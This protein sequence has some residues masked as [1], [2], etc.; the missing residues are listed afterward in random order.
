M[1]EYHLCDGFVTIVGPGRYKPGAYQLQL[2]ASFMSFTFEFHV[3]VSK[4]GFHTKAL[5]AHYNRPFALSGFLSSR[6]KYFC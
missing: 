3:R 2:D 4:A 6:D 5:K 1:S